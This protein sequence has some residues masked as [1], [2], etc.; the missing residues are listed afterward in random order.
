MA[1]GRTDGAR[2]RSGA[3][4]EGAARPAARFAAVAACTILV[5]AACSREKEDPGLDAAADADADGSTG[6][7]DFLPEARDAAAEDARDSAPEDGGDSGPDDGRDDGADSC[8]HC[9]C[10]C[11]CAWDRTSAVCCNGSAIRQMGMESYTTTDGCPCCRCYVASEHPCTEGCVFYDE[12][13]SPICIEDLRLTCGDGIVDG[14]EEC[15]PGPL[16][17]CVVDGCPVPGTR[18]ACSQLCERVDP[19]ACTLRPEICT[20]GLDDDCD[21]ETDEGCIPECCTDLADDDGDGWTDCADPDCVADPACTPCRTGPEICWD[22]CDND[23]DCRTDAE[24]GDCDLRPRNCGRLDCAPG[25]ELCDN[26]CDDDRDLATDC[27]DLDCAADP[28]CSH[29]PGTPEDYFHDNCDNRVDDDCDGATDDVCG[30]C[31]P[32]PISV[33]RCAGRWDDDHDGA[34]DCSDLD[35]RCDVRC[36][37]IMPEDCDDDLDNDADTLIDQADWDC[38]R[39]CP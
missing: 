2:K 32:W 23:L 16:A 29:C 10:D 37:G 30:A 39:P 9:E 4:G 5:A 12:V 17:D 8:P 26:G 20:N 3:Q 27:A 13:L 7:V 38:P 22:G 28:A 14:Y 35:C 24:D 25:A 19:P 1:R 21:G 36:L 18:S 31:A 11:F 34:T 33:E 15:E 6:D